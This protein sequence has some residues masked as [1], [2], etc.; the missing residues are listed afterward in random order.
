MKRLKLSILYPIVILLIAGLQY[1]NTL[2]HDY[3]WDDKLVI[4]ANP[5][6]EKG[7][8]GIPDIFT[9]R[10]SVPNKNVY[11]PV[12]Q[13]LFALEYGLFNHQPFYGHFF[14][15]L[16]Y[17]A[18]CLTVYHFIRFVFPGLD[19]LF[20][21]FTTL[22]FTVHP[23]HVE[24]VANIKSRDEILAL[25]FGLW[26]IIVWVKGI[27]SGSWLK[28][29]GA[30]LLFA[31][32]LLAKENA[33]TL[34]PLAPVVWWFRGLGGNK[35]L[36]G[37]FLIP[38]L[39]AAVLY[40]FTSSAGRPA[41]QET[42]MMD[43]TVLNNIFLWTSEPGKVF[44]T[45][46]VNIGRYLLLFIFPH[47][48]VHLYGYN[49]VDLKGWTD[50]ETWAIVALLAW[51]AY[52]FWK[53][54][55]NKRPAVFGI[56][57]FALTYSI[58]SNFFVL[59]PDTMA[60]RYLFI[61]SLGI[62][63]IMMEICWFLGGI[64]LNHP[65]FKS[66]RSRV[67]IALLLL[68]CIA[69]FARTWVGN[70]DWENDVT[71]IKNRIQYMENNAAAQATLGVMLYREGQAVSSETQH[72]A[73]KQEAM[74]AYM[75]AIDIY[76]D[77]GWAWISVGKLF[78]E[79]KV[80]DKAELA[81]IKAQQLEPFNPDG[82]Y[83]LGGLYFTVGQSDLAVQ[84]LEKTILL[85]PQMEQ[86]FVL[87]GKAYLQNNN[88]E[89]LGAL[90]ESA[91]KRFPANAEFDAFRAAYYFRN[92]K[93]NEAYRLASAALQKAPKNLLALSIIASLNPDH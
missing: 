81:F 16:W 89:S 40:W 54:R 42:V 82:Y 11:R 37:T 52:F 6:T 87:L 47:P 83:C 66:L 36:A 68:L 13:S 39:C 45:S 23:L 75:R 46:L 44:P 41:T 4:T 77:F 34:L 49:Q 19:L 80:F 21:F 30:L 20:A 8:Q 35:W 5:A 2:S 90:A 60:D 70:R 38:V 48:L 10:V 50:V 59:A 29:A 51:G 9:R 28:V 17:A 63:L 84:Y 53:N 26:A 14:S 73:L 72:R 3:A 69:F 65:V 58:Y 62:S 18:T 55:K 86:A 43:S 56:L 31:T 27:E 67:M 85:D 57:F 33:V 32:A 24:V 88:V 25:F 71:L 91:Q 61:P 1:A 64:S 7:V 15:L 78:A 22:I 79:E 93:T 76:P 92:G 12:T 74:Q